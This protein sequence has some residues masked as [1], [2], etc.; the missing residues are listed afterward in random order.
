MNHVMIVE[1]IMI[2]T[3]IL[4][5]IPQCHLVLK[6]ENSEDILMTMKSVLTN[7]IEL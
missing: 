6:T 2:S 1:E 4:V 5:S 3:K 7:K